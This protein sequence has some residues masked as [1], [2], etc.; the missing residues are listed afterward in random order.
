MWV[1]VCNYIDYHIDVVK[2]FSLVIIV[3][4]ILKFEICC[5]C[6]SATIMKMGSHVNPMQFM[7]ASIKW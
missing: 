6:G 7:L 5:K 1:F 2:S 3:M 4:I